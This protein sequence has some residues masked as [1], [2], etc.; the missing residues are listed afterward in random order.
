MKNLKMFSVAIALLMFAALG[1]NFSTA[2]LSG[3]KTYKD[4]EGTTEATTFKSGDTL[5]AK[6]PVANNPDN[7][8]VEF[9][10]VAEDVKE[11]NKG[12]TLKGSDV[13]VVVPGDGA[14]TYS[15]PVSDGFPPGKYM[16]HAD[17]LN[18]QGEKKDSKTTAVTV[19]GDEE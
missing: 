11:L 18:E 12:E 9:Y 1:C 13:S 15:V 2:N 7:V 14:A 8:K 19:T 16:L 6:A 5:Y 3:L 10:L 17:M 4:K